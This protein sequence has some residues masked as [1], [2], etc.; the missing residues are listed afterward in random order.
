M[1][2]YYQ[3]SNLGRVRSLDRNIVYVD[4]E[5]RFIKGR[6]IIGSAPKGY[7][8]TTLKRAWMWKII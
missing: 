1:K 8:I 2:G 7:K 5:R 3:A 6:I 4:G